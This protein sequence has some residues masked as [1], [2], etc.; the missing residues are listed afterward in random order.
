MS[1]KGVPKPQVK[2]HAEV[3]GPRREKVRLLRADGLSL[4]AIA[5][6]LGVTARTVHRDER[7][8]ALARRI[9][10]PVRFTAEQAA[11]IEAMI[12]DECPVNEIARTFGV[13]HRAIRRQFAHRA[14][15]A[16]SSLILTWPVR[17]LRAELG[18]TAR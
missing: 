6:I 18:L 3:I 13:D 7:A 10:L 16:D 5:G 14:P 17:R 11:H 1:Q 9:K 15:F 12:D 8:L 4:P 2:R